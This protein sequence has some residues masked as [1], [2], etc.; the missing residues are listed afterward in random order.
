MFIGREK[1]IAE[2]KEMYRS[3]KMEAAIIYGQRK[4]GKTAII[5]ESLKDYSGIVVHY[6][7]KRASLK[8]I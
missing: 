2:L 6:E 1:E 7:C 3:N 5:N 4:V 8:Q